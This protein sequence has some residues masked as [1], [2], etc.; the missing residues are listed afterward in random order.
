M[1]QEIVTNSRPLGEPVE[2]TAPQAA[3]HLLNGESVLAIQILEAEGITIMRPLSELTAEVVN[4]WR[5][6]FQELEPGR[7]LVVDLDGVPF[8]DSAGLGILIG[9]IRRVREGG[10]EVVLACAQP[11]MR[12]LLRVS[13]LDKIVVVTDD[14]EAGR[15]VLARDW[16][17]S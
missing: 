3:S 15:H 12:R 5:T 4:Q 9:G 10:G 16:V 13:G 17:T 11:G 8:M 7:R 2:S 14:E 1:A 6:R